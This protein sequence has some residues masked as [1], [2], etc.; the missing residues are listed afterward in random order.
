ML[1][2]I[3]LLYNVLEEVHAFNHV[4]LITTLVYRISEGRNMFTKLNGIDQKRK[5]LSST[6]APHRTE[7]WVGPHYTV[8]G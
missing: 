2:I 8:V 1:A 7:E 4:I 3:I 6:C 5:L